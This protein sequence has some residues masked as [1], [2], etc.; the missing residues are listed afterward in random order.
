M[1][2][3]PDG[4][5]DACVII[6]VNHP[7]AAGSLQQISQSAFRRERQNRPSGAQ[8]FISLARNL[9]D[10]FFRQQKEEVRFC[11]APERLGAMARAENVDAI[12]QSAFDGHFPHRTSLAGRAPADQIDLNLFTRN[13]AGIYQSF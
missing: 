8:I 3:F 9:D 7:P 11:H 10:E 12:A 5:Q 1:K 2:N 6:L 13:F 4:G